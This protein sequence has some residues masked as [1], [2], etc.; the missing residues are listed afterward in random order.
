M[1]VINLGRERTTCDYY[2]E[3]DDD[4]DEGMESREYLLSYMQRIYLIYH[5]NTEW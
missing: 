1:F 3:D 2:S 5:K 4:D